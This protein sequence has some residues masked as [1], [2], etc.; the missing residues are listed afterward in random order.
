MKK[1]HKPEMVAH[2]WAHQSQDEARTP[3][4]SLWF[5]H[6]RIY[7]YG[8]HFCIAKIIN[9]T[10]GEGKNYKDE[11]IVLFTTRSYSKTTSKHLYIVGRACNHKKII[12]CNDPIESVF[13]NIAEFERQIRSALAGVVKAKKPEK[14]I[15]QALD[16]Y[17]QLE[18]YTEYFNAEIPERISELINFAKT[19]K[20]AEFLQQEQEE[21]AR[22]A[23]EA[24]QATL[25]KGKKELTKWRKALV[26]RFNY[27]IND[28][29]YLRLKR[30]LK[31]RKNGS[32]SI[33]EV[34]ET[35]QGVEIPLA[36]GEKFFRWMNKIIKKGGCAPDGNG[37]GLCVYK[38]LDF[39]VT[40][41]NKDLVV[42]GCHKIEVKEINRLAKK[43]GW[44]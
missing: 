25:I 15:N 4:G 12:Y 23:E 30:G 42:I 24:R 17:S 33:F 21:K 20:Y 5:E 1:V 22:A 36:L 31:P 10:S 28:R 9:K 39:N 14:Y 34:I 18:V 19:G 13:S 38:I 16:V 26:G 6:D 43:L 3:N 37:S 29:D 41:V 27:R 8:R 40:S 32:S 7:S 35:S 11:S 2:L 44:I